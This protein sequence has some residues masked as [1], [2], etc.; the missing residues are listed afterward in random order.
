MKNKKQIAVLG[1]GRFGRS[2]AITLEEMGCEVLGVDKDEN[3]IEQISDKISRIV[4]FDIRDARAFDQIGI[5]NFDIVIISSKNLESSLMATMICEEKNIPEIIVK[6]IDERHAEMAKKLGATKIIFSERDMARRLAM[7][8][9][10]ENAIDYIEI[11]ADV[12]I[13]SLD[14][15]KKICGKNLITSNLR[16]KYNVN[17]IAIVKN[18]ET[19]V[20]P[21]PT[22]IFEEDE[23]IFLIGTQ[24]ALINFEKEMLD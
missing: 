7:N 1:L 20:N 21:E 24:D 11:A 18:S 6:A 13:L 2:A 12:K 4:S 16:M 15:P 10:S 8:L 14:M 3:V 9:I 22:H 17:L 19:T 5:E 23:K